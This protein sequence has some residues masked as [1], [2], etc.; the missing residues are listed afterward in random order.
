MPAGKCR[1]DPLS[2]GGI[3]FM[4]S[5]QRLLPSRTVGQGGGRAA[6]VMGQCWFCQRRETLIL[7]NAC[8]WR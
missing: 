6:V 7:E 5:S 8:V 4:C 3:D 2:Q 1:S